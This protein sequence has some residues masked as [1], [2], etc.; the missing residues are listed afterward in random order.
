MH[1][2][3]VVLKPRLIVGALKCKQIKSIN[4]KPLPLFLNG[5]HF[6]SFRKEKVHSFSLKPA[7]ITETLIEFWAVKIC[8]NLRFLPLELT[9]VNSKT[10]L[11]NQNLTYMESYANTLALSL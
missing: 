7:T 1:Q 8:L 11:D 3:N 4:Q 5:N 10:V 6:H 9:I 2:Q